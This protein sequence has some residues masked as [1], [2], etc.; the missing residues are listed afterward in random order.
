MI[1]EIDQQITHVDAAI[2]GGFGAHLK[3]KL[4]LLNGMKGLGITR[5]AVLMAFLPVLGRLIA[6]EIVKLVGDATPHRAGGTMKGRRTTWGGRSNVRSVLYMAS[7]SAKRYNPLRKAFY[8]RLR[9]VGKLAKVPQVACMHKLLITL[10]ALI[11]SGK[12]WQASFDCG[13]LANAWEFLKMHLTL[14]TDADPLTC[15]RC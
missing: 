3:N 15:R 8:Q 10:N 12:S 7:L 6:H 2:A 4:E 1:E 11:K 14:N 13:Q 5:K 9:A